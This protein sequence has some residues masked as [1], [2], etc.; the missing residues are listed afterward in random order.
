MTSQMEKSLTQSQLNDLNQSRNRTQSTVGVIATS[1]P[2]K[3]TFVGDSSVGK[4]S[5]ITKYCEEKFSPEGSN[6]TISVGIFEK[7]IKIDSFTEAKLSI[8]DTAGSEKYLSFTKSYLRESNGII[9]VF[10]FT[11]EKSFKNLDL[12]MDL[13]DE[14]VRPEKLEK[15]LVGNKSDLPDRKVNE[16]VAKKYAGE[17]GMKFVSVSAKDGINI[18]FLFEV[19]ANN[20][21]KKLQE[22]K[23]EILENNNN[24]NKD[25][26]EEKINMLSVENNNKNDK[27]KQKRKCC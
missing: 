8:W 26:N 24:N 7:S 9:L 27:K 10:D 4:T 23:N 22:D 19:V 13:I 3:I 11:N 1:Y 14:S 18:D 6:P 25:N 21:V 15:I 12:W 2:L 5:L 20:C 16:E 17:H